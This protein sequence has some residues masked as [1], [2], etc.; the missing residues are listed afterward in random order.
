MPSSPS[1]PRPPCAGSGPQRQRP[2]RL[3]A[4]RRPSQSLSAA[5]VPHSVRRLTRKDF[6]RGAGVRRSRANSEGAGCSR[7]GS[8]RLCDPHTC[9]FVTVTVVR[10]RRAL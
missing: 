6:V 5:S 1:A 10:V 8:R 7:V 2:A 3:P 4:W 9:P